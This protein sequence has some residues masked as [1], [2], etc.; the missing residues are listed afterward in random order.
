MNV[1]MRTIFR[2]V[3]L[4]LILMISFAAWQ[5]LR[6]A[7]G[8]SDEKYNLYIRTGMNYEQVVALLEKDTVVKSPAAFNFMAGRMDYRQNVKAG[9]YEI[10]KGMSLLSILRMLRNGR[11]VPVHF[12]I[13]KVRTH[14]GLASMIG[15]KFESDSA[16]VAAF[17]ANKDSLAAFGV[18]TNTLLTIVFPNT[19]TYFWN[20]PP[21]AIF[22]KMYAASTAWWTPQRRQQAQ[23][24]GLTPTT[25]YILAS[26]V[27]EETNATAD[28]GKIAS[29]Y[30]NR[31]AKG[32]KLGADPTVKFA[33]RNFELK[34]IYTK[35][36]RTESPY[37]TYLYAG[38]PPGPI[39]TPTEQTLTAVLEAPKTDYLFFVAKPDLQGYSNFAA[40]YKEHLQYR[41]QYQEAL[42]LRM[43]IKPDST[44]RESVAESPADSAGDDP[45]MEMEKKHKEQTAQAPVK[46]KETK[47]VK[48]HEKK[49]VKRK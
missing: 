44:E 37:N 27:E 25:A 48:R 35:Y 19:Y 18:D 45:L 38:L 17:M 26:I 2:I 7:T 40:T 39:C 42:N 33:M 36:T 24:E 28:K 46:R 21:S 31:M 34:R 14:E 43:G 49:P 47:P 11:Q 20:T 4:V 30:L 23:S 41:K 29:V 1:S 16:T 9:K 12:T 32:M 6:P 3:L 5:L 22:K 10:K 8:F 13:A 15:R